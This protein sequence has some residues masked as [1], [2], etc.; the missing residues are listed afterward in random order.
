MMVTGIS[1]LISEV[2]RIKKKSK[3][4]DIV[5]RGQCIKDKLLPSLLRAKSLD[6]IKENQF[7]CDCWIMGREEFKDTKNSWEVLAI[8]QHYGLP[9]RLLDWT[10]S[11]ISAIFFAFGNCIDCKVECKNTKKQ[12][13]NKSCRGNPVIWLLDPEQMYLKLHR[14]HSLYSFTIGIDRYNQM[15]KRFDLRVSDAA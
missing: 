15:K 3:F 4:D 13:Q 8:M 10:S 11:L 5:F 2:L 6:E 7:Y 1:K 9:T 14:K 12:K